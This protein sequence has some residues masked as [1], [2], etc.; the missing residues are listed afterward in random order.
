[1]ISHECGVSGAEL[2][3]WPSPSAH[4]DSTPSMALTHATAGHPRGNWGAPLPPPPASSLL[5]SPRILPARTS[6][7]SHC[8]KFGLCPSAQHRLLTTGLFASPG[9]FLSLP[10]TLHMDQGV[11]SARGSGNRDTGDLGE[12]EQGHRR[13][14]P[15]QVPSVSCTGCGRAEGQKG[16]RTCAPQ[17]PVLN[18]RGSPCP[19]LHD[20]DPLPDPLHT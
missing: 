19:G 14:L 2:T 1:M 5:S 12:H 4:E 11:S 6:P 9:N 18:P 10:L 20:A 3:N 15:G 17:S 16:E 8:A 13:A 7:P